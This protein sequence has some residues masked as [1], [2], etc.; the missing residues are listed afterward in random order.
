MQDTYENKKEEIITATVYRTATQNGAVI[1]DTGTSRVA[2]LKE[3]Q[4][5]G[6]VYH[7]GDKIKVYVIE[8]RRETR[9]P[10]VTLSR[11][12]SGLVKTVLS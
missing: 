8:V 12:H 4:I 6:E 2:M 5:P 9:G 10:L 11:T 1:V 7:E 3:E